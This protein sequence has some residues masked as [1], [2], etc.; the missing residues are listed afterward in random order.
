MNYFSQ[1]IWIYIIFNNF[2]K[3]LKKNDITS[4]ILR[5]GIYHW[6]ISFQRVDL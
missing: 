1:N 3:E 5:Y 4:R 6:A 2:R